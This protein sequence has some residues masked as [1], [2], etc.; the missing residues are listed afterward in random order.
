METKKQTDGKTSQIEKRIEHWK[1]KVQKDACSL[2]SASIFKRGGKSR[3]CK[4]W[5]A[6]GFITALSILEDEIK[7]MEE[8]NDN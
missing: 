8:E 7:Q 3:E 5:M 2:G 1:N 6:I 4:Y